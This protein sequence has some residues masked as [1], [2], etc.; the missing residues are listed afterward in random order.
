MSHPAQSFRAHFGPLRRAFFAANAALLFALPPSIASAQMQTV[1][2]ETVPIM[3][4]KKQLGDVHIHGGVFMPVNTSNASAALGARVSGVV[5]KQLS[6][7]LSVD[8]Y[9]SANK[10]LGAPGQTLPSSVYTPHQ[11]LGNSVTQL[12]PA[13]AF[14]QLTPWPQA[15]LSPFA[16]IG[17]GYEWLRSSAN[18]YETGYSF[19]AGYSNWAWQ[20]FGGMGIRLSRELR[21]DGEAFYNAGELGRD[22]HDSNGVL[23]REV[24]KVDG[25]GIRCGL[26]VAY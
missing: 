19:R 23:G 12:I 5:T 17:A 11:V 18:D 6:V 13:M 26:N 3:T 10:R 9:F 4:G 8:W 1:D 25:A 20:A 7:G 22:I 15:H 16:G 14:L 2:S 21:L 24:V